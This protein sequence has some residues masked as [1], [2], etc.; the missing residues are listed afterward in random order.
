MRTCGGLFDITR[1]YDTI[2]QWAHTEP[3]AFTS[4]RV[5]CVRSNK[6]LRPKS[7]EVGYLVSFLL[8]DIF[9]NYDQITQPLR[10]KYVRAI[11]H[12]HAFRN[13]VSP[14]QPER[15]IPTGLYC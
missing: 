4:H 2:D 1:P 11:P 15:L 9:A 6:P 12:Y 10:N 7:V 13:T 5:E 14:V 3:D 8:V